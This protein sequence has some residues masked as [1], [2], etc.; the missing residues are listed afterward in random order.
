MIQDGVFGHGGAGGSLGFAD[1]K[2]E[3]GFGYIMKKMQRVGD[4]VHI[5]TSCSLKSPRNRWPN[6]AR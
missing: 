6:I 2:S 1:P 4:D 5:L 3:H